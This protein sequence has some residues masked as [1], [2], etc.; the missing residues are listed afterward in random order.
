MEV[1]EVM[2]SSTS[3]QLYQTGLTRNQM[4]ALIADRRI[5]IHFQ[6]IVSVA[7]RQTL[8][9]E[10]LARGVADDGKTLIPPGVLFES[11]GRA[12]L[13]LEFD[14]ACREVAI[15]NFSAMRKD[16]PEL[17]LSLNID[18][19]VIQQ[20]IVGS[21]HLEKAIAKAGLDSSCV[22]IEIIESEVEET[23]T[24]R[25][26][27]ERHR[28]LGFL[29]AIDDIGA[30]HSNFDRIPLLKPDILKIDRSLVR[31]I[32]ADYHKQEVVKAL[33]DMAH[34]LGGLVVAEGIED[35]QEALTVHELGA[36]FQQGF[37]FA[38]PAVY[39]GGPVPVPEKQIETVSVKFK[40]LVKARHSLR[41][42]RQ[43]RNES[44]MARIIR[45]LEPLSELEYEAA[46][47]EESKSDD[48][49]E[50]LYV[51]DERGVMLTN[52]VLVPSVLNLHKR[53]FHPAQRGTDLSLKDY[54]LLLTLGLERFTSDPYMSQATGNTCITISQK[55][56]SSTGESRI[57]CCDIA[58]NS[59][60]RQNY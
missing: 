49:L 14:R 27:T 33:T 55:F 44:I 1:T 2:T 48:A 60:I 15:D 22:I 16:N 40:T 30:G 19:A 28:D 56:K 9:V 31:A 45:R 10:A 17:L 41:R 43:E 21:G 34:R 51:T 36:D 29:L 13:S 5:C 7:R 39:V 58:V 50:C 53:I 47:A 35:D 52:T 8:I 32:G 38:R 59:A 26:F 18:T 11:A 3:P 46:L 24:L 42:I 54:C 6:P 12:G 37:Y 25:A 4:E 23:D 57:L 20:S